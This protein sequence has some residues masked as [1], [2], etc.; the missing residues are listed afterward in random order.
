MAF[1]TGASAKVA[2]ANP[3]DHFKTLT[4]RQYPDVMPHQKDIL[5]TYASKFSEEADVAVQL[6]TGSGKT[7]VGLLIADWRRQ[8][9]GERAVYLCPTKQLVKQTVT[10]ARQQYGID[11]VDLSGTKKKFD[12]AGKTAFIT[13]A[14]VAVSTYNGLFNTHPFFED[15]DL[16]IIDDAHAAENYIADMWSLRIAAATPL[17]LAISGFLRSHLDP[18][19]HSRL[20]GDW[21]ESTDSNWIEKL[22]TP[23]AARLGADLSQIIDAH[24]DIDTE[25]E[26]YFRWSLLRGHLDAC[27]IYLGSREILIR[28]LIPPT[29][30]HG[31]FANATQRI[32]MS[33]TLGKGGD[34]ERLTG[35]KVIARL[36]A[37]A[38]FQNAGV[39]R[40]FFI[41]PGLSLT[42][43][44]TTELRLSMQK[45]AGRS[46]ILTPSDAQAKVHTAMVEEHLDDHEVFDIEDIEADKKPFIGSSK[47]VAILANRFDG[48]DF[49]GDECRLLCVDGLP[50][51]MNAQE[52]FI[53]SKM[54]ATALFNERIQTRILQAVGR[55]TRALQD[56]SAVFITGVE[57]VDF[58]ADNRK[59]KY[60]HPELQAELTFGLHQ[61]T[62]MTA[63][64]IFENFDMFMNNDADWSGADGMIRSSISD[65]DQ[66]DFPAM[67][68]LSQVAKHEVSYQEAIW[69]KNFSGALTEAKTVLSTLQHPELRGYRALWHYL[70]GAAALKLSESETDAQAVAA[71][72]QFA[73]SRSAAPS[74]SW[75][76][77][78]VRD[79]SGLESDVSPHQN[80][81]VLKQ[82]E[83]LE[84]RFL[85]MG[86]V[87]NI[88]FEKKVARTLAE[89]KSPNS[90]EAGQ[91]NLGT[92]LGFSA[93]NDERD[94]A[95]DPWWLGDKLGIVF[96]AHADGNDTTIF[97]AI[98]ARQAAGHP[99]WIKKH[100]PGAGDFAISPV[101]VTPCV[102]AK[103]GAEPHLEDV[104]YWK[105][106]SFQSWAARATDVLRELKSTFPGEGDLLWRDEAV[107][108]LVNEGLT[109]QAIIADRPV[110]SSAMKIVP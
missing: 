92:L 94:A 41:F 64:S 34:L 29:S 25:P 20:T 106:S 104:G 102:S 49:P 97:G 86:T 71:R 1:K 31:P 53:M 48:I 40:R 90:F 81:E 72:I 67:E 24:A 55:C 103:S 47:A 65:F 23:L 98:K 82:V 69:N 58:L 37:P 66:A 107:Q 74:V 13:G 85:A 50:K 39:G 99:K 18:Q 108:K 46:L 12:P 7:L 11:V 9:F 105:L 38:D 44:E 36:K 70:A 33:A 89:L 101:L 32:F 19:D 5:E 6:P 56:R 95:P 2:S 14:K 76:N 87:N 60:F 75:L 17:H 59:W 51:A 73:K 110:A 63:Q 52:R 57:L 78:L 83:T 27:H 80:T 88:K 22:S 109:L 4:K 30:T 43:D 62:N 84:Q 8:K 68:E 77:A 3:A 96:E 16:I 45:R 10:Q 42:G 100:V 26:L 79:V 35:R 91:V 21:V 15:P 61:S 93:G 28:P 54:G